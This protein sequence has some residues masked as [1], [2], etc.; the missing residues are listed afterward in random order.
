MIECPINRLLIIITIWLTIGWWCV[1]TFSPSPQSCQHWSVQLNNTV[2]LSVRCNGSRSAVVWPNFRLNPATSPDHY[3]GY[4]T[5][6]TWPLGGQVVAVP[7]SNLCLFVCLFE[8][9]LSTLRLKKC[10]DYIKCFMCFDKLSYEYFFFGCRFGPLRTIF[11][12]FINSYHCHTWWYEY[13]NY[14]ASYTRRRTRTV[15]Q[16]VVI[17]SAQYV[18]YKNTSITQ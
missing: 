4:L 18:K 12:P 2:H 13:L 15:S 5:I 1:A 3:L 6:R 11:L 10:T 17:L 7:L 16:H 9:L 8:I 14:N